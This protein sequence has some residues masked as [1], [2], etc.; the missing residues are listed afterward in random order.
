ML[1][2]ENETLRVWLNP[3]NSLSVRLKADGTV[4]EQ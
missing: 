2:L 3:E 4:L 1:C